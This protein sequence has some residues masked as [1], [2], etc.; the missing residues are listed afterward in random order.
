MRPSLP[1]LLRI[2]ALLWL[3]VTLLAS[4]SGRKDN[5]R[6]GRVLVLGLDGMD[7]G[8]V[9]QMLAQDQLPHLSR[10]AGFAP[11]ETSAPPQ[12]PTAW[13]NF[14]TGQTPGEHGI[15]DFIHRNPQTMLP[16]L[17]TSRVEEPRRLT[18]GRLAIPLGGG[19]TTLLRQHKPFWW[20]LSEAGVPATIIKIPSH[21]P[22]RDDGDARVLSGMGTPDL[23]GTYGTFFVFTDDPRL[24]KR[25]FSGGQAVL[26]KP[27]G[28]DGFT[29]TLEGPPDPF[30]AEDAPLTLPVEVNLGMNKKGAVIRL[31]DRHVLL[32]QGQWSALTTIEFPVLEPAYYLSA[33][34]RLYL[35]SISPR[36]VLY[37]SP[38]NIDPEKPAL[39]ISSPPEFAGD[40][41]RRAGAFYTQGMPEDSKA[42]A[43]EV[44]TRDEYLKQA[45]MIFLQRR[46]MMDAALADFEQGLLY[47]YFSSSDQIAHMFF[48][49]HDPTHPAHTAADDKYKDV[50]RDLYRKMDAVVGRAAKQLRPE[51]LLLVISDHG[52]GPASYHFD[53]NGWLV[54]QGY[55]VL[56]HKP[57]ATLMGQIDWSK[58]QAYGLGLNGLYLNLRGREKDGV[59]PPARRDE[60]LQRISKD[61]LELRH[62]ATGQ[63]VVTQVIRPRKRYPGSQIHL[64][65]D[66]V[67]GYG[68]GFKVGDESAIGNAGQRLYTINDNAWSGDHCGDHRLV[69]GILFTNRPLPQGKKYSLYDLAPTVLRHFGVEVPGAMVGQSLFTRDKQKKDHPRSTER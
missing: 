64:A 21:F 13:S 35:K 9:Q 24:A 61:L 42:L 2:S 66:L 11:L 57:E 68:R 7:H 28:D 14:I 48:R 31:G 8:I 69:P 12:S 37:I 41:A 27:V 67:V 6:G 47:F 30:S 38:L 15:F 29:A 63:R 36:V 1:S 50:L 22:P 45:E 16:Y 10:L 60:L 17:S 62:P 44:L 25:Q 19:G 4:C 26:L 65:P 32:G 49:E 53:L 39:P 40:L 51:D 55:M 43:A 5:A 3:A 52:F 46:R 56:K 18:L 58:T 54:Q 34:V 59:V 20:Y 23:L 33:L